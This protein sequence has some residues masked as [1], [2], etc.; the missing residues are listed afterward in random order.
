MLSRT[1]AESAAGTYL[2]WNT[3]LPSM[4]T[5]SRGPAPDQLPAAALLLGGPLLTDSRQSDT[6][7]LGTT[8]NQSGTARH[9][10]SAVLTSP[11]QHSSS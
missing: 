7:P 6:E 11:D 2:I 5:M 4:G 10:C 8:A 3:V 9:N 1:E